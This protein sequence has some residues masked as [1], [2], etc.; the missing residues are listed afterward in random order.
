LKSTLQQ[1]LE[2]AITGDVR[3]DTA[4]R[5]IY[6]VDA[7]IYEIPPQGVVI[8]KNSQDI[9]AAVK[10]AKAHHVPITAR[11]AATGITGGCIGPGII[12]D[13]SKYLNQILEVNYDDETVICQPGVVQDDLNQYLEKAGYRLGPDTSTGNRATVG[14][15]LGNNAAGARSLFYGKM[16]DHVL[17]VDMVLS[18][19]EEVSFGEIH[20]EELEKLLKSNSMVG[21]IHQKVV[22]IK[23]TYHDKIKK[24]FPAIPRR[25]SGYNLDELIKS[26]NINLTK[27]IVGSE[28]TLGVVT[29]MKLRIAKRP[30]FTGFC[31]L[32]LDNM[33]EGMECIDNILTYSP[34]SVEMIDHHILEMGML[35]PALKGKTEWLK[36]TPE[37]I[38][39][40]EFQGDTLEIVKEKTE[41][42]N[43]DMSHKGI[44]YHRNTL[45]DNESM[46]NVWAMRKAGLGLLLS[47]RTYSRAIAFI[48]DISVPPDQLASFMKAFKTILRKYDKDAG[49]YGHVGSG[50]MHIRPYVDLR[51][52]QELDIMKTMMLEV[53]DILIEHG[54]ALSGEHGDGYIRSW[55]NEKLF[56]KDLY[57]AFKK[58]KL[59]FDP[60]NLM[61]PSKI[62][63]G[64][65]LIHD[66][67][68]S[69]EVIQ[70][71][72]Q[73]FLNFDKEGGFE[74]SA[75]LCN[76]NATC[77]KPEKLMC[78]PFQVSGD[79]LHTTRARAQ[80]LRSIVNGKLPQST[81]SSQELYD[82]MDLCIECKG[83]KKECP[84]QVDMAKMKSEFLYHYYK[85]HTTPIRN[86]L[87]AYIGEINR[88]L[89]PLSK[90]FNTISASSINKKL[91]SLLNITPKRSLPPLASQRF[92]AWVKQEY[93]PKSSDK[94]VALF[95]D[96]YTEFNTPQIGIATVKL[97]DA[98]GYHV[99]IIDWSCCGRP[100]ISK[101]M[102]PQAKKRASKILKI[103]KP[104]LEQQLPIIILE[105]SC[106][107]AIVD[108]YRS[109]L[110]EKDDDCDSLTNQ[111]VS[112]EQFIIK[113]IA[114]E[115]LNNLFNIDPRKNIHFHGHCH[116]KSLFGTE[117]M[118]ECIAMIQD[119][120]S[121]EI[122]TGCCGVA[123]SFG[124][125]KEHYDLSIKI[126]NLH[127][128]PYINKL[129]DNEIIIA[130]GVSCRNQIQ[131][132]TGKTALHIAEY[133]H[134]LTRGFHPQ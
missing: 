24:R 38:F 16:V 20:A 132:G 14:G 73:T 64:Q 39:V 128:F 77:R 82:V 1:H 56:G 42:F 61:N 85:K 120:K 35:A 68:I 114:P 119:Q 50:C 87:F 31:I 46:N 40:V 23:N 49:I 69:P 65:E 63:N 92:S 71:P 72:I 76:G 44:G 108:D 27:L 80:M 98:L 43:M 97:L 78:P 60:L 13:T 95:V 111:C 3:F 125:E 8:P 103:L 129:G 22:A 21:E 91:L 88:I 29:K 45:Y 123:G 58:V 59:A 84:S 41:Q 6:S 104:A 54:G 86:Y 37:A 96:T 28:G 7:S 113:N 134:S 89:T 33:I 32:F 124:Y 34:L 36:G 62:V 19:G 53:T 52:P 17:E 115:E 81:F 12:I 47:K 4:T 48:E 5:T 18:S 133:L 105:P 109:L 131:H 100:M 10:I 106:L 70:K 83:C 9:I 79:E 93:T 55:L 75:D 26:D 101:G 74:L 66:L 130:N 122:P 107:S 127:L 118:K 94:Q 30:K 51:S 11:G 102:L 57:E 117:V 90:L 99:K 110:P 116:Q 67:R 2:Q 112:F 121:Y 25:V 126:G 15:M